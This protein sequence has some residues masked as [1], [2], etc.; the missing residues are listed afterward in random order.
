MKFGHDADFHR[1][2][3]FLP[4]V[5]PLELSADGEEQA[6]TMKAV[7]KMV[8]SGLATRLIRT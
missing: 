4:A 2:A 1:F 7:T 3:V 6:D 5:A 8:D